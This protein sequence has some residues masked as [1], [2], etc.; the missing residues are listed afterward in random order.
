MVGKTADEPRIVHSF[1]YRYG[2]T[3]LGP[4]RF[5]HIEQ[6]ATE[7]CKKFKSLEQIDNHLIQL[8]QLDETLAELRSKVKPATS[9]SPVKTPNYDDLQSTLDVAKAQRLLVARQ[10]AIESVKKIQKS[11]ES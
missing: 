5:T 7:V 8:R 9:D 4:A 2:G 11:K 3:L 1:L 10:K 6:C